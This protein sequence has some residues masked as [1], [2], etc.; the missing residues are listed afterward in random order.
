VNQS[1]LLTSG[2]LEKFFVPKRSKRV[3]PKSNFFAFSA[4]FQTCTKADVYT[5]FKK[6]WSLQK[7]LLEVLILI[8]G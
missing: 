4:W 5:E 1:V 8:Y 7:T 2:F 3:T 6:L